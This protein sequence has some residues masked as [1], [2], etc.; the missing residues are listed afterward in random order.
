MAGSRFREQD[1]LIREA[2]LVFLVVGVLAIIILDAL[3]V[4]SAYQNVRSD[5][6]DAA[7]AANHSYVQSGSVSVAEQHARDLLHG[8]GDQAVKLTT[9]V[10]LTIG[11][12]PIFVVSAKRDAK[13]YVLKYGVHLPLI[14]K[15]IAKLLVQSATRDSSQ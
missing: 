7:V 11:P 6:H 5:A 13:T 8:N 9:R 12:D 14:G 3:G 2:L 10:D 15:S 1:G 4:F